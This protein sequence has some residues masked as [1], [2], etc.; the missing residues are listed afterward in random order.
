[1]NVEEL[2]SEEL[3]DMDHEGGMI[4]FAGQRMLLLNAEA[5]GVLRQYLVENI[6]LTGAR[7]ILTQYGFAHGWRM[8]EAM[9]STFRSS[10]DGEWHGAGA[11]LHNLGGLFTAA[12]GEQN[13]LSPEGLTLLESFEA[14]QHLLQ[15][16]L[17]DSPVCWTICGLMSGY[18]SHCTGQEIFVLEDRCLG[19]GH[20]GCHIIGRTRQEWGDQH[21]DELALYDA[22]RLNECLDVSL[23]KVTRTLREV[24]V[25]L[26][27]RRHNLSIVAPEVEEPLGI[28]ARS[29]HMRLVVDMARR[30]AGVD[31]TVLITGE[32]G[33][34]KERVARLIH[35]ES[36]RRSRPFISINC[37]AI[38]ESLLESELFGHKRGSFTGANA[39]RLG[40]FETANHGTLL[41]DEIG[42]L[43]MG[44]QVKLLRVLQEREIR[45]VGESTNR[46]VDV[47]VLAATNRDLASEVEAGRF[48]H[49]LYYRLKVVEIP[50]PP[51]RQRRSDILPL[52]RV[53]L[54]DAAS[55][56]GRDI[57]GLTPRAADQLLRFLWP[58]NVRELENAMERAAALARD[59]WV[60]LD[61]L[62]T[63]INMALAGP[64]LGEGE[65][66]PLREVEKAYILSVL[67]RNEGNQTLTA[68]Q[69]KIGSATLYRKLKKWG[70]TVR[71]SR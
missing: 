16:G 31:L 46:P 26:K 8:A 6:G 51:L 2:H 59:R 49:D 25:K 28:I 45:R 57:S 61:D 65:V 30:V 50:V 35:E 17:A 64:V 4:R 40:L 52:A 15:L 11:R 47:R 36:V 54:A 39:D 3:L 10:G 5:M 1:M 33:V 22:G 18:L 21:V 7:A 60:D 37:G 12:P 23:A 63:E 42:D 20:K 29:K 24:E 43:P 69:L 27:E 68:R 67:A 71:P 62:P 32:S 9:K 48:R 55:R 70:V 53:M 38:T 66:Q 14:E 44:M 41:L 58:G 19:T 34:G 13:P 56:M